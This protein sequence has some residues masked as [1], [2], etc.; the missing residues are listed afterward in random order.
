LGTETVL[1]LTGYAEEG[2]YLEGTGSIIFDHNKKWAYACESPRTNIK[3][4]AEFCAKIGYEPISFQATDSKGQQ[5]YH[6]NVL[7]SVGAK[8][9]VVCLDAIEDVIEKS[10]LKERI[11]MSGKLILDISFLQMAAFAG[12]ALEVKADEKNC[13]VL[14][15][16]AWNSLN[17]DQRSQLESDGGICVVKIPTIEKLGGGSARCMMAGV[18]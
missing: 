1:D 3:L 14:S 9:V 15:D 6:T 12:N 4:L 2:Q 16:T 8:R 7:M 13:W 11:R 5:I 10:M 17:P 18:Y